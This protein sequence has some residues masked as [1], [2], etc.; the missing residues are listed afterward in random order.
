MLAQSKLSPII[1]IMENELIKERIEGI[2]N[3]IK[4]S[5]AGELER[6]LEAARERV[7]EIIG[8]NEI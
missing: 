3:A 1:K 4:S 7:T 8:N 5:K 6:H 2:W